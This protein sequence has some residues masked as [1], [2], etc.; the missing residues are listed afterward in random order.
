MEKI[1]V[2][3]PIYKVEEFL[4]RCLESLTQQTYKNLE[5]I[6]VNDGSPD[7]SGALCDEWAKKDKR[8]VV[9]HKENGGVSAARN[10]GLEIATGKYIGFVDPDDFLD[11]T[12]Y[13]KLLNALINN[14]ADI[15]MC[16]YSKY[17]DDGKKITPVE[18]YNLRTATA[19][20]LPKY[21]VTTDSSQD[22]GDKVI[23]GNVMGSIWRALFTKKII[24]NT[25]F[26]D[27]G[28]CEDMAFY[29]DVIKNNPKIT[30]VDEY[31]YYYLIRND[32]AVRSRTIDALKKR[33]DFVSILD[34]LYDGRISD[35]D[36]SMYKFYC[37]RCNFIFAS[38]SKDKNVRKYFLN[39]ENFQKLNTKKNYKIRQKNTTNKKIRFKNFLTHHNM[40]KLYN[41]WFGK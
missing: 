8:I 10:Y 20:T 28:F 30:F 2:I 29:M 14:K 24:G 31:L 9:V 34:D 12:M 17:E 4:D 26:R 13:E 41:L 23:T 32:S 36:F 39:N 7:N 15:S 33:E 22:L 3:V 25:K 6:L 5:I 37:Y 18:E 1:S 21:L 35:E 27:L 16:A 38:V 19:E 11:T 40:F